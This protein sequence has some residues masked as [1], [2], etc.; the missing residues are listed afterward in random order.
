MNTLERAARADVE[1]PLEKAAYAAALADGVKPECD[2]WV[3]YFDIARAVL[4]AVLPTFDETWPDA[5]KRLPYGSWWEDTTPAEIWSAMID[6]I[7][8]ESDDTV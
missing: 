6:A 1:T 5:K 4:M 8:G 2:S 7:L 3:E